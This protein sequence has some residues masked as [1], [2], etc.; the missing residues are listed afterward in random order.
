MAPSRDAF[1]DNT[2]PQI[3][4]DRLSKELDDLQLE[5]EEL[6]KTEIR[7]T[8]NTD[9]DAKTHIKEIA[10]LRTEMEKILNSEAFKSM[11]GKS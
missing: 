2:L 6:D 1:D 9:N 7:G 8:F 3:K 11:D 10:Y 4:I 5:L